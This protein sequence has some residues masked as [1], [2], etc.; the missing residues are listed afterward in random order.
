VRGKEVLSSQ[1]SCFKF[2]HALAV[3]IFSITS[4]HFLFIARAV[5]VMLLYELVGTGDHRSLALGTFIIHYYLFS[6]HCQENSMFPAKQTNQIFCWWP[7][8]PFFASKQQTYLFI[9]DR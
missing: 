4:A 6:H 8:K 5:V 3:I 7:Q 1:I 2:N 9:I